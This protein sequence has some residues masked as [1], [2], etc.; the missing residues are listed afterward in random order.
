MLQLTIQINK[1]SQ[2]STNQDLSQ[3]HEFIFNIVYF[4][5]STSYMLYFSIL[6][7]LLSYV[8]FILYSSKPEINSQLPF[9]YISS[10]SSWASRFQYYL[11]PFSW[12]SISTIPSH[13]QKRS[14]QTL[15][16]DSLLPKTLD[17]LFSDLS[18]KTVHSFKK[19]Q[20]KMTTF[21]NIFS[22]LLRNAHQLLHWLIFKGESI[23]SF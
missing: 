9:T 13:T 22:I 16:F 15:K 21:Q 23:L 11:V 19:Y 1:K 14:S 12:I 4:Y 3:I 18:V 2:I 6:S 8:I 10:L 5:S 20:L 7:G 17:S